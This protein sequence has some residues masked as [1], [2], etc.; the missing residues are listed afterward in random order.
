MAGVDGY[1]EEMQ[2]RVRDKI[3]C[4]ICRNHFQEP[5]IL[6]CCHYYCK[7]C[8]RSLALGTGENIPFACPE[9]RSETFL[10]ENDPDKLPTAFF[11]NRMQELHTKM[12]KA[13]GKVEAHCEQCSGG[14]ATAFCRQC[15]EFIC[16]ECD[17]IHQKLKIFAEHQV[18][19]L[20][21]LKS[22]AEGKEVLLKK[23]PVPT[24]PVHDEE[25]KLYCFC[26]DANICRD[27]TVIDHKDHK[28]DFVKNTA[29]KVKEKVNKNLVPLREIQLS[30]HDAAKTVKSTK[31]E[32]K[33]Q[34]GSVAATI[35][36]S[37]GELHKIIER[38]K[39]ELLEKASSITEEKLD[40]LNAQ[41]TEFEEA[42]RAIQTL[43]DCVKEN[44]EIATEEELMSIHVRMLNR[45]K[46]ETK[47]QQCS[48]VK[49][50]PVEKAN[51]MLEVRCAEE[52]SKMC[53]EKMSLVEC[54]VEGSGLRSANLD[55][56][57][58]VKV[59]YKSTNPVTIGSTISYAQGSLQNNVKQ[60]R[61]HTY[62]IEYVPRFRCRHKLHITANGLPLAG[63]PYPVLV[64]IDPTNLSKPVKIIGGLKQPMSIAINAAGEKL[65]AEQ[66][67][68]VKLI[69]KGG[70]RAYTIKRS[71]FG[72]K[73]LRGIA[74][75][76]EDN[77]Y[78]TDRGAAKLF[79]FN[80]K[81]EL[82][83][84]IER[85]KEQGLEL[86]NPWEVAI[87]GEQVVIGSRSP[88]CLYFFD[89]SLELRKKIDLTSIGV[90]DVMGIAGDDAMNLYI[91]DYSGGYVHI[92]SPKAQGKL[93]HSFG[94]EKLRLPYSVCVYGNLVYVSDWKVDVARKCIFVFNK[95]G[96]LVTSF[97]SCGAS[98]GQLSLPS[99]L[100]FDA[101]SFLYVCDRSNNRLQLF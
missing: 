88:P 76:D 4:S 58:C 46:E 8:I 92:L 44:V 15:T 86:F 12:A 50:E 36:R 79:K 90:G 35:E 37:F 13:Q 83:K 73:E 69:G 21:E 38:R 96:Q 22:G 20:E 67:G 18:T 66:Y 47:R 9:C 11:A 45:I 87:L 52:L 51:V 81:Y 16:E 5:K 31:S 24:C 14:K 30:L 19:T 57:A 61:E 26:C 7:E 84:E 63:S 71:Q 40:Q 85:G 72:F 93:L 64:T 28:Y 3:T 43:V 25:L 65:I 29:P 32:I 98:D 95:E 80:Q 6:P 75:D 10:P 62:E 77:T 56:P 23:H 55:K 41:E 101:D 78:L 1:S 100:A 60:T 34:A 97:G 91:C 2:K 33:A 82:I 39:E 27:C 48:N 49:L 74:V 17:K 53:Q 70:K 42:S 54:S 68:D 59:T 89:N 99:G 94:K